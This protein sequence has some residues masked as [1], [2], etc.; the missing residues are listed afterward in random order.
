MYNMHQFLVKFFPWRVSGLHR[1][2]EHTP[3]L[4]SVC[5]LCVICVGGPHKLVNVASVSILHSML[6]I[7]M[8]GPTKQPPAEEQNFAVGGLRVRWVGQW[9]M[10]IPRI[11]SV[12][13]VSITASEGDIII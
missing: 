6:L 11:V 2:D 3:P 13:A 8:V 5:V 10:W 9:A 4:I 7:A 12:W 1:F